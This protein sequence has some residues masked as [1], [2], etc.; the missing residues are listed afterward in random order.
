MKKKIVA[1]LLFSSMLLALVAC[2]KKADDT[3]KAGE[4]SGQVSKANDYNVDDYVTKL[5]NYTGVEYT[6]QDTEPTAEE[7]QAELDYLLENFKEE[8]KGR[9]VQNGDTVNIDFMGKKDGVAFDGGTAK[10]YDLKI[11]SGNF[12]PG[13][14][15]GLVGKNVGETVDLDLQFPDTYHVDDLKGAKVVFTVTVNKIMAAPDKLTDKMVAEKSEFKTVK[16]FTDNIKKR[17]KESKEI[18]AN[19]ALQTELLK[20]VIA[21]SEIK[22]IPKSLIDAYV[23]NYVKHQETNAQAQ[24]MELKDYLKKVWNMSE[25]DMRKNA[26][27]LARAMSEQK[28]IIEA[29]A[30]KEK[31][32]VSEE[33]YQ[34]E[35][36]NYYNAS[37]YAVQ[38]DKAAFEKN[39]GRDNI[40]NIVIAKKVLQ[41]I[42]EKGKEVK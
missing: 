19:N 35:L 11:G 32:E 22:D 2:G 1:A 10:G 3:K 5:G 12:I 28:L 36:E 39:I 9:A 25:E 4:E 16:E 37:G 41:L 13:F 20:K 29:I 31:L 30:K 24:N 15:E 17:I 23:D 34:L 18:S 26:E 27:S 33:E 14:E 21:D 38:M 6:R 8:V 42:E 7:I 40:N